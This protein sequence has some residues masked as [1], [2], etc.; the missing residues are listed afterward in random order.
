[1]PCRQFV[2]LTNCMAEEERGCKGNYNRP[3]VVVGLVATWLTLAAVLPRLNLSLHVDRSEGPLEQVDDY[4]R[5]LG[6]VKFADAH[7]EDALLHRGQID[8]HP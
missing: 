7:R 3:L 1:M 5:V 8:C 2:C 4:D 6:L